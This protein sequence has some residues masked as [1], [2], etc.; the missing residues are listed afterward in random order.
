MSP[1]ASCSASSSAWAAAEVVLA[2]RKT[3]FSPG[4]PATRRRHWCRSWVLA[5]PLE[6]MASSQWCG[7][8]GD[9]DSSNL[10]LRCTVGNISIV[11]EQ[12]SKI[13]LDI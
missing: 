9:G 1:S 10:T 5:G 12:N 6:T 3:T 2:T 4:L 8:Q 11:C 13:Y 7:A